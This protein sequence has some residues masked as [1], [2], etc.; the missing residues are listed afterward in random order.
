MVYCENGQKHCHSPLSLLILPKWQLYVTLRRADCFLSCCTDSFWHK[1]L[2]LNLKNP[3]ER[4]CAWT[5]EMGQLFFK[6]LLS[7]TKWPL[8]SPWSFFTSQI[9]WKKKKKA[10]RQMRKFKNTKIEHKSE[11]NWEE[12]MIANGRGEYCKS[13][14]DNVYY[15]WS[16][17]CSH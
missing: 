4:I 8:S 6:Q 9:N 12:A 16:S 1:Q 14:H 5:L 17:T 2:W 15:R 7:I 3:R 11:K 10:N 13:F